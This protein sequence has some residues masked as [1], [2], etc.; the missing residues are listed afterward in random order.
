MALAPSSSP[1]SNGLTGWTPGVAPSSLMIAPAASSP[2]PST[3]P[4]VI[5][6]DIVDLGLGDRGGSNGLI[7]DTPATVVPMAGGPRLPMWLL[8]VGAVS[9]AVVLALLFTRKK[10]PAA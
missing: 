1:G 3:T 7:N 5:V 10:A 4:L 8:P 9:A 6:E 2:A